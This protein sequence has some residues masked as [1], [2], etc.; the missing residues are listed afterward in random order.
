VCAWKKLNGGKGRGKLCNYILISK[1]KKYFK[2]FRYHS[3]VI[4][5]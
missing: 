4:I 5:A 2:K 1:N 3:P